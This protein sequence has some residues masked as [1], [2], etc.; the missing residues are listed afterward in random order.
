VRVWA[1]SLELDRRLAEGVRPTTSPELTLR[2]RQL[3]SERSRRALASALTATVGAAVHA[4]RWPR[5]AWTPKA[6]IAATGVRE[7]ASVLEALA[8]ELTT[9]SDLPVRGVALVSFLVCDGTA[10]PLYNRHSPV[11]VRELVE[12]ARVALAPADLP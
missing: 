6:P 1:K 3:A 8:R 4:E 9:T 11:S 10:S 2:A 12:R 5:G 7:A